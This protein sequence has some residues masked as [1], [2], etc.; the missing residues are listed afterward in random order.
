MEKFNTETIKKA[1]KAAEHIEFINESYY[2]EIEY[3]KEHTT[4]YDEM[5]CIVR[6]IEFDKRVNIDTSRVRLLPWKTIIALIETSMWSKDDDKICILN[7]ADFKIPGGNFLS[8]AYAQEEYLCHHST[9]HPVL[10]SK[11][12]YYEYNNENVLHDLYVDRC[13]YSEDIIFFDEKR[14]TD[15]TAD[16]ITMAAPYA[17]KC[18]NHYSKKEIDSVMEGRI[19]EILAICEEKKVTKLIL[20]AFGCGVFGNDP[21]MTAKAFKKAISKTNIKECIFAIPDNDETGNYEVFFNVLTNE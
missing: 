2:E 21:L 1:M 11:K 19:K 6:L 9:L 17:L 16:V 13:L 14:T 8:G 20:G 15:I 7:F 18:Q 3:S 5:D 4:E 12:E 10:E